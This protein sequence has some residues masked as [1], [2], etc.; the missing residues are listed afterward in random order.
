MYIFSSNWYLI[1]KVPSLVSVILNQKFPFLLMC[2]DVINNEFINTSHWI[3]KI[4]ILIVLLYFKILK[5]LLI[6]SDNSQQIQIQ[7]KICLDSRQH[8]AWIIFYD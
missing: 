2:Y 5:M 6:K 1:H 7:N 8:N 3:L 4:Y